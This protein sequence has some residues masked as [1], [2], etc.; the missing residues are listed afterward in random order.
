MAIVLSPGRYAVHYE[1]PV[2]NLLGPSLE[3]AAAKAKAWV[4]QNGGTI[5][6]VERTSREGLSGIFAILNMPK[7]SRWEFDFAEPRR[8]KKAETVT[9]FGSFV[10][11]G[12]LL[13]ERDVVNEG[14][15]VPLEAG[16]YAV[17]IEGDANVRELTR[18]VLAW[19]RTNGGTVEKNEKQGPL[20][21]FV[22]FRLPSE[23]VWTMKTVTPVSVDDDVTDFRSFHGPYPVERLAEAVSFGVPVAVVVLGLLWWFSKKER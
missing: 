16:R 14:A 15:N 11:A 5:E 2:I 4:D 9:D 21:R 7:E 13:D 1:V 3:E 20:S 6:H 12:G 17:E 22:L 23:R 18:A 19:V 8:I 10:N